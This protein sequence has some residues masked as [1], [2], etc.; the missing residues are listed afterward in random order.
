MN[1]IKLNKKV[2]DIHTDS[3]LYMLLSAQSAR[4]LKEK[5]KFA[6]NKE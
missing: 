5:A 6:D 1:F 4:N 2:K 3:L